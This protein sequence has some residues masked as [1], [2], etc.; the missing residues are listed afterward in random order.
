[1]TQSR[2]GPNSPITYGATVR[3][4]L[5]ER[6]RDAITGVASDLGYFLTGS[7]PSRRLMIAA[8]LYAGGMILAA[9]VSGLLVP[10]Q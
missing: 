8:A 5:V 3:P 1:M 9:V 10:L 7:R 4:R 2:F 6:V